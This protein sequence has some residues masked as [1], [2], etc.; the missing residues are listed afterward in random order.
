MKP[1]LHQIWYL[2]YNLTLIILGISHLILIPLRKEIK[3][4]HSVLHISYMVHIPFYTVK[5][6][7]E[8]GMKADYLAVGSSKVWNRCDYQMPSSH[9]PHVKAFQE[10][11]FFWTVMAK[12]EIIHSHFMI[13]MSRS[14]WEYPILKKM[15]RKLVIHYRGCEARHREKNMALHPNMNICQDCDY[16]LKNCRNSLQL[17]PVHEKRRMLSNQYGDLFLTTTPDLKDFVTDAQHFPFFSPHIEDEKSSLNVQS[18][19]AERNGVKIVH[20]TNHPGIEGTKSISDVIARLNSKGFKIDFLFLQGVPY[21]K[22]LEELSSAD[23]AIGKMKMGYYANAQIES[24]FF[25]VPTITYVRPEF[26]TP[27]LEASGFILTDLDHLEQTLIFYLT[28]PEAL[29]Q[30]RTLAKTSIL[31]LHDNT[32][33]GK[34]LIGLY[35]GL[36]SQEPKKHRAG[37]AYE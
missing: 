13:T 31:K 19:P 21:G 17:S 34:K 36:L 26:M 32:H 8:L 5:I 12:Y 7:R 3:H 6:L 30:K 9:W 18:R 22:V 16:T 11:R 1:L 25:G 27:E 10:F 2:V 14:G 20:A 33:L 35:Q 28:H 29:E 24:M 15:G 4:D 37:A 23:L